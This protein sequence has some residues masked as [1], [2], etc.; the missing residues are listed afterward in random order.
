M[1]ERLLRHKADGRHAATRAELEERLFPFIG[2]I[3][4]DLLLAK[5]SPP[6]D[7]NVSWSRTAAYTCACRVK[8]Q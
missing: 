4:R 1:A 7:E 2:G 5:V 6:A 3:V 8:T